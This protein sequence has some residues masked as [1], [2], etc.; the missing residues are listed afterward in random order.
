MVSLKWFKETRITVAPHF[1]FL[2]CKDHFNETMVPITVLGIYSYITS[3]KKWL[4]AGI[5][6]SCQLGW[7]TFVWFKWQQFTIL[8]PNAK[9]FFFWFVRETCGLWRMFRHSTPLILKA[10]KGSHRERSIVD[11]CKLEELKWILKH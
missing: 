5:I 10:E 4:F 1:F 9:D 7:E 2:H 11:F 3:Y 6:M 8:D